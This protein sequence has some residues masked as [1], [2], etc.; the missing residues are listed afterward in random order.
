MAK[1]SGFVTGL[2]R[3]LDK[4]AGASMVLIMLIIVGNVILRALF[5]RPIL[6]T[7]EYVSFLTALMIGLSLAYCAVQ[8]GHIAVTF[9]IEKL[10][11]GFRSVTDSLINLLSFGF[12]VLAAWHVGKYANSMIAT[13]V[14]SP[15]TQIPFF[16]FVYMVSFGILA[17]CLVIFVKFVESLKRVAFFR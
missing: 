2:S 14:V 7:Y 4:L 11:V 10:P 13:G 1:I 6:G 3:W 8:N 15:T 16:P 9:I 17:L 5:N 12:W